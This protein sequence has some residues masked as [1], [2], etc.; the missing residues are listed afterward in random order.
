MI[1]APVQPFYDAAKKYVQRA[2]GVELDYSEESLAYVDHYIMAT[3]RAE[4]A[5]QRLGP[6]VLAL[7]APAL[8]AYLG[9][10][11]IK[12]FGG[13]WVVE[14]EPAEWRV[15]FEP[16]PLSFHP[17]GMAAEAL[18]GGEVEGYNAT[19]AARTDLMGAL[20]EALEAAPPVDEDYYYS[21]TGRFE[22]LT[23]ALDILVELERINREKTN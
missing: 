5:D 3:A 15:E 12:R 10:V 21:L 8:G 20:L 6:E 13:K 11:A 2:V 18:R 9:Q 4:A 19:F 16:A 22:T 7:V 23:H 17:V 1:P 14:G